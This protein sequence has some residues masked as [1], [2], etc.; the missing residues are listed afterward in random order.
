MTFIQEHGLVRYRSSAAAAIPRRRSCEL[1]GIS[2]CT[3]GCASGFIRDEGR[4]VQCPSCGHP[5]AAVAFTWDHC[6]KH[7]WIRGELCAPCNMRV[8]FA[9]RALLITEPALF[10]HL[11]RCPDCRAGL[12]ERR[13]ERHPQRPEP[14]S[15]ACAAGCTDGLLWIGC[16][17]RL[18][19][20]PTCKEG[21]PA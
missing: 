8:G 5:S 10:D 18:V 6:H 21:N 12:P 20:C 4:L 9:E 2:A 16:L 11:N 3:A 15:G 1:C 13:P 7:G 17:R 19:P 14:G